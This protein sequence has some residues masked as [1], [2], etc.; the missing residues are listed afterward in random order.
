MTRCEIIT[1]LANEPQQAVAY[2][3]LKPYLKSL[4]IYYKNMFNQ[5]PVLMVTDVFNAA[6]YAR[7]EPA[8]E[9]YEAICSYLGVPYIDEAP[10]KNGYDTDTFTE[11]ETILSNSKM[12]SDCINNLTI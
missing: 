12:L 6:Q 1:L 3:H 9:L 5:E 8:N 11:Y 10:H 2:E 4:Y 7:I